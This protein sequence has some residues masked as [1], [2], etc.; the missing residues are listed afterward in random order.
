MTADENRF[1]T[2][3][4]EATP[5]FIP[6]VDTPVGTAFVQD[7]SKI[8]KL[9]SPIKIKNTEFANRIGVSPMCTYSAAHDGE[10]LG[11][12]TPFHLAHYGSF[13]LRGPGLI[14]VEAT[15]VS[16]EGRLSP[17]DLAIYTDEQAY[18]LKKIVD[19][20]H[21]Q[22]VKIGIQLGHGGRKSSGTAM[23]NHL[24]KGIGTKEFGWDDVQGKILAPS[25]ISF[26]EGAYVTPT[27]LTTEQVEELVVKFKQ[28][29]KRALDIAGFDFIEIHG[30]HGYLISSF[31]TATSNKRTD[32]YGGSFENR[33][34]LLLE[35]IDAVKDDKH[36]LFVRI[37]GSE[38]APHIEESWK[39]EDSIK[40][41]DHLIKHGVDVLDV[42]AGGQNKDANRN[43]KTQ[44]YQVHLAKAIKEHV[45]DKLT[46]ATV[47]RIL[48]A[49]LAAKIVENG[50]ADLVFNGSLF[51]KNPG[52]VWK[53]ADDLNVRLHNARQYGWP[54]Y[55]PPI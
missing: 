1:L 44:G 36:P 10:D 43:P 18:E 19:F 29:A 11:K 16:P 27:E 39:I 34:R 38:S 55:P 40:L 31:L 28:A 15:A 48:D 8:P 53:W 13:A 45:G 46:I 41:S 54:F 6:K 20:A 17:E 37:S 52:L 4:S 14:I 30:A 3:P 22:G 12:A 33:I 9:F 25:A 50:E 42:S 23:Y 26:M 21:S 32:K 35:I 5:Y 7:D 47:G 2:Q 49:E 24:F 51:L